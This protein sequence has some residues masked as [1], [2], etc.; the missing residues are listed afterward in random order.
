MSMNNYPTL[1]DKLY[2]LESELKDEVFLRQPYG[3][4]WDEFTYGEVVQEALR[5]V[6]AMKA[7]GLRA[8][9]KV[10]IYSKNCYQWVLSEIAIM[11]GGFVTVPFY[12]N[13]V[14]NSLSEVINLSGIKMLFVGKLENWEQAR[15]SVPEKLPIVR[16]NHYE[17]S[18]KVDRGIEWDDFIKEHVADRENFRPKQEDIWAI[19]YTSG[20]TGVPKGVVMPYAAPA[21]IMMAQEA[22][23]NNFNLSDP[24]I[25]KFI[26]YLPL[27]HIAEQALVIT[28]GIYNKGQISFVESL[29]SF[30]K[31]LADVQPS[32]FLAVPRIWTKFKQ[33]VLSKMP[34]KKL[35]TLLKIPIISGL[36]KKKIKKAL[37]LSD[38]KLVISGAS[39]LPAATSAWFQKLGIDIRE[40]FGMTETM[41]V[42]IIQP[43]DDIRLGSSGKRLE[44][45]QIKI[46]PDTQ[47]IL[48]KNSW[49]FNGYYNEPELTKESFTYDGYYKTGDT[50]SLDAEG[51]L[52]VMGR[53]KDTFKT[54][55]GEFIVPTPIEDKFVSN[56][57]IEQLC[58][59]GLGLPQPIGLI[60]LSEFCKE[61]DIE[62]IKNSLLSTLENVN[63]KLHRHEVI[64]KLICV[65][66]DWS[67]ENE[68]L[69]PTQK[70]KR[71]VIHNRYNDQYERWYH[72]E[73]SVIVL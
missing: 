67:V 5:I 59:V 55:K 31:N 53:V 18:A 61:M 39:A 28:G 73:D 4:S 64:Q 3:D 13:L 34:E 32:V 33:G 21:N 52:K 25:N 27:N 44:E 2:E 60:K 10:G 15:D 8:G 45:G 56:T 58:I 70:I 37:G 41:G 11:L 48:V 38:T 65:A 19:F 72:H 71:N 6:S 24:G 66:D 26:S 36:I 20:T 47:E 7:S 23:H 14:E 12:A 50:G 17:G 68:M 49:T 57:L 29:E 42:V 35:N 43:K 1:V 9:D 51:Y 62:E 46:D 22:V 63:T 16:F 54:S 30:S 40:T 69:T